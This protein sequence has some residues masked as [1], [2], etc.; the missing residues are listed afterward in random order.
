ML[1]RNPTRILAAAIAAGAALLSGCVIPFHGPGD[2]KRDV[3]S[4]TGNDLD[5]RFSMTVGRSAIAFAR[6]AIREEDEARILEGLRK[7]EIGIYEVDGPLEGARSPLA[8]AHWPEWVPMVEIHDAGDDGENGAD[9]LVLF[10]SGSRGRFER[11]LVLVEEG[12]EVV[13][14]RVTGD[15]DRIIENVLTMALQEADHPEMVEPTLTAWNA[16]EAETHDAGTTERP[17]GPAL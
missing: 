1:R 13:I 9:V 8:A 2:I 15:L 3:Q 5:S 11:I 12:T 16:R 17:G 6:W 4:I 10:Q 14:V 7:V